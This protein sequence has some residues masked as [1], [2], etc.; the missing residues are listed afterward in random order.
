[1]CPLQFGK[2]EKLKTAN[3]AL[4]N[5]HCRTDGCVVDRAPRHSVLAALCR[6]RADLVLTA[7]R[8]GFGGRRRLLSAPRKLF[9][10]FDRLPSVL[11]L[12][13]AAT[14][15]VADAALDGDSA[16]AD[17]VTGSRELLA[18]TRPRSPAAAQR[19]A[20]RTCSTNLRPQQQCPAGWD[21]LAKQFK[22]TA[23]TAGTT[24][25]LAAASA[26]RGVSRGQRMRKAP[27]RIPGTVS[28]LYRNRTATSRGTVAA[29]AV[30]TAAEGVY[31]GYCAGAALFRP[32]TVDYAIQTPFDAVID[33]ESGDWMFHAGLTLSAPAGTDIYAAH[34]GTITAT[35]T[36]PTL[37]D[38]VVS[39]QLPLYLT[40]CM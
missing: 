19:I 4:C 27:A 16:D 18:S 3:H 30:G 17:S 9:S 34:H 37:G 5:S 28:A 12:D 22:A 40:N 31:A 7:S 1:M 23:P 24:P 15:S 11:T 2:Q 26:R 33:S 38:Y 35:G 32:L 6:Y 25:A 36:D 39:T 20:D 8:T 14:P 13:T 10:I 21:K 29:K